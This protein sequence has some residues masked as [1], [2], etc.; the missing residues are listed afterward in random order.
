MKSISLSRISFWVVAISLLVGIVLT[1]VSAAKLCT[2][3][4]AQ[5]HTY[6]I[7]GIS[8]DIWGAIFFPFLLFFLFLEKR[9]QTLMPLVTGVIFAA[10]GAELVFIAVQ[11]FAIKQ[12]C[13]VCLAIAGCIFLAAIGRTFMLFNPLWIEENLSIL[14]KS[15]KIFVLLSL[16]IFI[17]YTGALFTV[18]GGVKSS[19]KGGMKLDIDPYFGNKDSPVEVYILSDWF[20]PACQK[21]EPIIEAMIPKIA[22]KARVLF[23][24]RIIH[25]ESLN[26]VPYNLSLM[27]DHKEQYLAIRHALHLL[28]LQTKNPTPEEVQNAI[29]PIGITL[30]PI[31]YQEVD[32]ALSLFRAI[33]QLFEVNS[34]PTVVVSNR[35]KIQAQKFLGAKEIT[36]ENILEAIDKLSSNNLQK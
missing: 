23:V 14:Q 15:I 8:F 21:A 19:G 11:Q 26:F 24:D 18:Q 36:E 4:C 17:G 2:S 27:L 12:F 1:A 35:K 6:T 7:L 34:T 9:L 20:C 3:S 33:A 30:Q 25:K 22:S 29:A 16:S 5:A 13:L 31:D 10:A 28:A 32:S